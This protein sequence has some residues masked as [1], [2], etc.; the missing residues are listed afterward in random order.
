MFLFFICF[1]F[2]LFFKI[3]KKISVLVSPLF[4][5]LLKG[6]FVV[7]TQWTRSL[8]HRFINGLYS[9]NKTKKNHNRM[10]R[11]RRSLVFILSTRPRNK[12]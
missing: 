11:Q 4:V 5:C 2:S 12:I 9:T 1:A 10:K 3:K 6:S 7:V 8:G